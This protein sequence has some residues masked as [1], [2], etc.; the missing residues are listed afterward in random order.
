M[1][2]NMDAFA[3][4]WVSAWNARDVERVL[5]HY[6]DS[7]VFRSPRAALVV[8]ESGGIVRGKVALRAY[9][10]RALAK[11]TDLRFELEAVF[12]SVG[13]G[14]LLYSNQRGQRVI[15]SFE[16]GGDA[17]EAG[18]V[19]RSSAAYRGAPAG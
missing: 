10:E 9:W 4:A 15:E 6:A 17:G 19:V 7:I 1:Q 16:F 5:A 18:L 12:E 13:G 3:A 8:P 14:A 11:S 2:P